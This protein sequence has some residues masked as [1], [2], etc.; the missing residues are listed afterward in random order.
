MHTLYVV[1]EGDPTKAEQTIKSIMAPNEQV[2]AVYPLP[3]AIIEVFDLG[4]GQFTHW[5][6]R[7]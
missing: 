5:C 2:T 6:E 1:A 3:A 4:P 7:L